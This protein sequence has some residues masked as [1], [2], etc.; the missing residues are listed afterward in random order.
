[1]S[2]IAF[3]SAKGSPGVT[4]TVLAV[5]VSWPE[6]VPVTIIE[7]DPAGGDL[8]AWLERPLQPGLVS[9]AAAGRRHLDDRIFDAHLQQVPG[10]ERVSVLCGPVSAEQAQAALGSLRGGLPEALSARAGVVLVDC[11]RLDTGSVARRLFD[12]A[13][14]GILLCRPGVAAVHHLQ[15]R[16]GSFARPP[17]LLTIGDE[18][19]PPDEIAEVCQIDSLGA[20]AID[21]RAAAT[22]GDGP[23]M[24]DRA[25][26]RSALI[27]TAHTLALSLE[28]SHPSRL[29]EQRHDG[30]GAHE[31]AGAPGART[32][33]A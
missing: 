2:V 16:V 28:A 3:A 15:A 10:S 27:R 1:M 14:E 24:S 25:L 33:I 29:P 20:L 5:A 32:E 26:R 23:S 7:A 13:D 22:L 18:P 12:A 31:D 11:G 17:K 4:T 21:R 6:P 9:L 8:A 30:A 19:Y